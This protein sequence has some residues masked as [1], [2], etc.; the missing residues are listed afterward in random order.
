MDN[1][2]SQDLK[3]KDDYAIGEERIDKAHKEIFQ[4]VALLLEKNLLDNRAAVQDTVDF[5]KDYV[6]RHFADEEAY[7]R[8]TGYAQ[9]VPHANEHK[10]FRYFILPGIERKLEDN[11]YDRESVDEFAAILVEWLTNHIMIC[12]KDLHP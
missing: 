5:M 11:E 10:N 6:V 12:D 8:E 7:M 1:I 9:K 4:I 2:N 3:W